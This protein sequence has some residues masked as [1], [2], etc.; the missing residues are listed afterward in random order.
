MRIFVIVFVTMFHRNLTHQLQ[1]I[2]NMEKSVL[3][4]GPRQTGKTTLVRSLNADLYLNLLDPQTY[5]RYL[6]YPQ[7]LKQEILVLRTRPPSR[8][9]VVL[10]EVQRIPQLLDAVQIL[11]DDGIAQFVLTGSSVK[12]LTNLLPGRVFRCVMDPLSLTEIQVS[13]ADLEAL[14]FYGTLPGIYTLADVA[15]KEMALDSYFHIYLEEE[16]RREALVR[17]L[18]PFSRFWEAMCQ[19]SGKPI[20]FRALS[21]DIGVTHATIS[22]YVALLEESLLLERFDPI[23][24]SQSRSRL[25]KSSK[26]CLFDMGIRR[27][28][29]REGTAVSREQMG[30]LFEHYIGLELRRLCRG[31]SHVR[32]KFWR[33]ANGPEVDWILDAGTDFI[34]IEV[35]YSETPSLKDTR[36]VQTFMREYPSSHGYVVCQ[37]PYPYALTDSITAIPWWELPTWC[38]SALK[39]D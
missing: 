11:I 1:T 37:T 32:V 31:Y 6:A 26:Y 39:K 16:I 29:A 21:Q 28:G 8:P 19:Q 25:S 30:H 18:G 5:T 34:P 22:A 24:K 33:D 7:L 3:L 9:L 23:S 35:K 38:Q 2:L 20:S 15:G 36:H 17:R 13:G 10:D 14:L 12:K 4:I 27:V